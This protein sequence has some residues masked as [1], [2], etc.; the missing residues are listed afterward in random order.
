MRYL[1]ISMFLVALLILL[2]SCDDVTAPE[3]GDVP[4][5]LD[6]D[7]ISVNNIKLTWLYSSASGD[8]ITFDIARKVGADDWDEYFETG[9]GGDT[10]EFIDYINT[11]DNVVYAYKVRYYNVNEGTY[12][13]FSAAVA[14]FSDYTVPTDLT[15]QQESQS[16]LIL[17]WIDNCYGEE[18]YRIDKKIGNGNWNKKYLDLPEN[19][20]T[21]TDNVALFDTLYYRIYAFSGISE[22]NSIQ[23]TI[24]QTLSAPSNLST[25]HLDENKIRLTWIDNS[26]QEEGFFIDRKVGGLDW[27]L[28][29]ETISDSNA[30]TFVDEIVYPSGTLAYR[31]RSYYD[32]FTSNYCEAD[33]ININLEIVGEIFTPGD[34]LEVSFSGWTAFVA[35]NYSGLAVIN[36]FTPNL[37]TFLLSYDLA[38]RT[39]S[40]HIVQNFAYVA[41]HSGIN[42]PGVIQK[43]DITT[44]EDP[45]LVDF[46][47]VPGIPKDIYVNGDYAYIAEGENG[48]SIVYIAASNLY[49][50]SNYPLEDARNVY[51]NNG[52]AFVADG[53]DGMKIISVADPDNPILISQINT[54]GVTNDVFVVGNY[55]FLADGENGLKIYNI[56]NIYYPSI[57]TT[58][59]TGGFVIA[60]CAED[61][62]IYVVDKE[63]GFYV[64]DFSVV[65]APYILGNIVLDTEPISAYLSGSYV[66]ITD[67]EGLKIIQIKP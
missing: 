47:N 54:S 38:D 3:L 20:T 56:T 48:L 22:S 25:N 59:D 67:N 34:A 44:L 35:D 43:I 32:Q 21:I 49:T 11:S 29:Y 58:I 13:N 27:E 42:T 33:T 24:F 14:Y 16:V 51:V 8:T 31:V 46:T 5:D 12:S 6:L 15:I 45:I 9:I 37:P 60:V 57:I 63:K 55:A 62:Y 65:Y 53:L 19:T 40:S 66:Y 30:T 10:F 41:S 50:V 4:T 7:V 52:Y 28:N 2:L 18:G 23:D 61:D 17:S 26:R 64:V 36:C 39:L 1:K